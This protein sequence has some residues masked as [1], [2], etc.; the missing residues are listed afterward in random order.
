VLAKQVLALAHV[1]NAIWCPLAPS[2]T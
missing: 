1:Q 2:N